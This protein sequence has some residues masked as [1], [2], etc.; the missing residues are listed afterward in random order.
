MVIDGFGW[1]SDGESDRERE[2][3]CVWLAKGRISEDISEDCPVV[4][5]SFLSRPYNRCLA[6]LA[7]ILG[8]EIK[9]LKM[10]PKFD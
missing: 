8:D 5:R 6:D 1:F 4:S 3:V 2:G 10:S 7:G 9:S